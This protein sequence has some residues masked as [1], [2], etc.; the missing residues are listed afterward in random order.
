MPAQGSFNTRLQAYGGPPN[1]TS[2]SIPNDLYMNEP[3]RITLVQPTQVQTPGFNEGNE[4][5]DEGRE[6]PQALFTRLVQCGIVQL[7]PSIT[8]NFTR[9][10]VRLDRVNIM[11]L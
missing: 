3:G 8:Q 10:T 1:I 6:I 9:N 4:P 5:N 11:R 7:S 2:N